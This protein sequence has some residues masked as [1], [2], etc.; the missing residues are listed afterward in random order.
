VKIYN[1]LIDYTLDIPEAPRRIVSLN[2]GFTEALFAMGCGDRVVGVSSYCD[3]YVD[4]ADRPVVGDYLNFDTEKLDALEPDLIIVT[5]GI[6][7]TLAMKLKAAAYPVY[8]LPLSESFAG[9]CDAVVRLGALTGDVTRGR[10]LAWNMMS[11]SVA[12][13]AAWSGPIPSVSVELWF[14]KHARTIGGRTFIHDTVEIAGGHPIFAADPGSYLALNRDAISAARPDI[15]LGFHEPE[16]P[17]DFAAELGARRWSA[18]PGAT[19]D[20]E[21]HLASL[22]VSDISRGRNII[23]DGPSLLETARWLQEEMRAV[24]EP[25]RS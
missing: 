21:V 12:I 4:I 2:S 3:R 10:D 25:I 16:F 18:E 9:V 20:G 23:H 8:A 14:G 6:Q 7:R 24:V 17:V 13:R 19:D 22:I 1:E 5:G 15:V 11:E